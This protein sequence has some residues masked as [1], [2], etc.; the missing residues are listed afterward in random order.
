LDPLFGQALKETLRLL[1]EQQKYGHPKEY[2]GSCVEANFE[3]NLGDY[4]LT[5][6]WGDLVSQFQGGFDLGVA[7]TPGST[8]VLER[9]T[10][11]LVPCTK[12]L[13][14][15]GTLYPDIGIGQLCSLHHLW[16]LGGRCF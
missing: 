15:H 9:Q 4:A 14:P 5:Y 3:L 1:S 12:E 13:C 16:R 11:Q 2:E 8:H 7:Q 10:R 6:S